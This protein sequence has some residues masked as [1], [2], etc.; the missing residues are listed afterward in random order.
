[1]KRVD[2]AGQQNGADEPDGTRPGNILSLLVVVSDRGGE[3]WDEVIQKPQYVEC[4]NGQQGIEHR[5]DPEG[6]DPYQE[7]SKRCRQDVFQETAAG[8]RERNGPENDNE[9][10]PE[11]GS[12]RNGLKTADEYV[13][14]DQ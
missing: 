11:T 1:M 3:K 2:V 5:G 6:A 13:K 9:W 8:K 7:F 14:T 12:R 4:N 10:I